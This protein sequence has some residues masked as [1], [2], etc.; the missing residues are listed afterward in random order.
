MDWAKE[1]R[2]RAIEIVGYWQGQMNSRDLVNTFGISQNHANL[3][4]KEYKSRH[5]ENFIYNASKRAYLRTDSFKLHLSDGSIDEYIDHVS[6]MT[7]Q[8]MHVPIERLAPHHAR[9]K[10][11]VVATILDCVRHQKG[12][13]IQYASM[14]R[15]RGTKRTIYPH[16]IVDTGFRWHVRAYCEDRKEF[17]DF[18]LG[19]ILG[20][21]EPVGEAPTYAM[22]NEDKAWQKMVKIKLRANPNLSDNQRQ[23]IESEFD[24]KRK[25]LTVQCKACLIHYML[26]MFQID[27]EC[28]DSPPITQLLAV[29]SPESIQPYLFESS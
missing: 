25:S 14:N 1:Q 28:L 20:I 26:Q 15:P 8:Q 21:P 2:L 16:S 18:N 24:M 4:I 6:R 12:L 9:L 13:S 11:D 19:R 5:P 23:V 7:S 17:R 3:D 27:S 22:V 10:P 29:D